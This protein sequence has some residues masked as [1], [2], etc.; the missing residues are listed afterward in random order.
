MPYFITCNN[1]GCG[2][3]TSETLID[4]E[5]KEVICHECKKEITNINAFT[6]KSMVD[7]GQI[8]RFS[9]DKGGCVCPKCKKNTPPVQKKDTF[10]CK[11]CGSD[12]NLSPI[13]ARTLKMNVG[14]SSSRDDEE[15]EMSAIY[16]RA[17]EPNKK[18]SKK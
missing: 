4:K 15:P 8:V 2:K 10:V 16:K 11:H 6:K 7:I 3:T 18:K 12:L 5:T 17:M 14:K 13:F 9:P 1:S